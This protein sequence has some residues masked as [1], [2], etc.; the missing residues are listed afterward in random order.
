MKR[1]SVLLMM[2]MLVFSLPL[3]AHSAQKNSW[4][5]ASKMTT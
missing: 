2:W 3:V 4:G 1:L 5:Q